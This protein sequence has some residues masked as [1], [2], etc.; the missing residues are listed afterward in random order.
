MSYFE[1]CKNCGVVYYG[2][3]KYSCGAC[4]YE[5]FEQVQFEDIKHVC[6]SCLDGAIYN[7]YGI[8]V[9]CDKCHK[10]GTPF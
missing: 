8:Q 5:E 2:I 4:G 6:P 9:P 3:Q 7:G 10:T 1:C